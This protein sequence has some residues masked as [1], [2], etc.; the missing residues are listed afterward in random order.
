MYAT[1]LAK[2]IK[3]KIQ[4][5]ASLSVN[6]QVI[7][8]EFRP[9]RIEEVIYYRFDLLSPRSQLVLKLASVACS[10]ATSFNISMLSYMIH[11]MGTDGQ[12]SSLLS[13]DGLGSSINISLVIDEILKRNEFIQPVELLSTNVVGMDNNESNNLF[14]DLSMVDSL[15]LDDDESNKEINIIETKLD[16]TTPLKTI[17]PNENQPVDTLSLLSFEF[18]INLEQI[19]IYNLMLDEQKEYLHDRV[20]SYLES[21]SL[22]KAS[23]RPEG[24]SASELYEEGFHWERGK[25]WRFVILLIFFIMY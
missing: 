23:K 10:N 13:S 17:P 9:T 1:E 24:V 6:S 12:D 21:L 11:M 4:S 25:M 16:N 19:T 15:D 22:M 5:T 2:E 7:L 8:K 14:D 18:K 20:A 3:E